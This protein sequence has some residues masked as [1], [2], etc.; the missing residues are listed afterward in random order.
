MRQLMGD[1]QFTA[2][3]LLMIITL[4]LSLAAVMLKRRFARRYR[5]T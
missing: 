4:G 5:G 2:A 3:L 1:Y